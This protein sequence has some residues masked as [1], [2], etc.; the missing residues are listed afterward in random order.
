MSA[1]AVFRQPPAIGAPLRL[2]LLPTHACNKHSRR[3]PAPG[4][5]LW[6][7]RLLN[8]PSQKR[9][10][11]AITHACV[12]ACL[13]AG[14]GLAPCNVADGAAGAGR[15]SSQGWQRGAAAAASPLFQGRIAACRAALHRAAVRRGGRLRRPAAARRA[16]PR[17]GSAGGRGFKKRDG[18]Q[19]ACLDTRWGAVPLGRPPGPVR[20]FFA[21]GPRAGA[22]DV[23]CVYVRVCVCVCVCVCSA[24]VIAWVN[25]RHVCPI[26]PTHCI[27]TNAPMV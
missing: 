25:P 24:C 26:L 4:R 27:L 9:A 10:A 12:C 18:D 13:C 19:A 16:P 1:H 17:A 5:R 23:W 2:I 20:L 3:L 21:R 8:R 6:R 11:S 22:L 14:P 15:R 7:R